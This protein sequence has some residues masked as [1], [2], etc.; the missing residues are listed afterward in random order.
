[1]A[2]ISSVVLFSLWRYEVSNVTGELSRN[3]RTAFAFTL[4]H[5][6]GTFAKAVAI[7]PEADGNILSHTTH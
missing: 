5:V 4:C 1:M 3:V 6:G 7:L 2:H